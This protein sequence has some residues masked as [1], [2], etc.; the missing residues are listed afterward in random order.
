MKIIQIAQTPLGLT[1][2]ADDGT[3]YL[4]NTNINDWVPVK[5]E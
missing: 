4:W 1:G 3:L 5:P 2:L